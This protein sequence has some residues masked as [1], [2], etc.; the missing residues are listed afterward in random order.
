MTFF[1]I[2]ALLVF[3]AIPDGTSLSNGGVTP[4]C[5]CINKERKPIGRHI[6]SVEVNPASSHCKEIEIIATLK[7]DG[8]KICLDPE[9]P[10]VIKCLERIHMNTHFEE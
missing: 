8:Q 7:K 9:A 1:T 2:V 4:R 6:G 10:W 5:Q 3:L